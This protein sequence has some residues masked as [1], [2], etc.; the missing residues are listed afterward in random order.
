M[1]KK[2][3]FNIAY[4][5]ATFAPGANH[6]LS[7]GTGGTDSAR[8]CYSVWLRHLVMAKNN[9]LNPYP[10]IVAELGPGDS[11]GIGLT[12]LISGC[13]KYFA[14]DVVEHGNTERNARIFDE[15]VSLLKD[16]AAI[17]GED[18]FP[19]VKPYL[20]HYDFP[21]DIFG[22]KRLQLALE[23]SR[24]KK[25]RNAIERPQPETR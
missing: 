2:K 9:G 24:L 3:L 21:A 1:N 23:T 10:K 19:N 12:A 22:E 13:D 4:G 5:L 6:F 14:F 16:R 17:P 20:D 25:I 8:Y 18:E 15:I 7:K 11:L